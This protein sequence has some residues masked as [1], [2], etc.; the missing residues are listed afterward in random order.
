MDAW[1]LE[2]YPSKNN[3]Y[4]QQPLLQLGNH[5]E[6]VTIRKYC[7]TITLHKIENREYYKSNYK[8]KS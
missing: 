1:L 6:S 7:T 8:S 5:L 2:N 4:S 3:F